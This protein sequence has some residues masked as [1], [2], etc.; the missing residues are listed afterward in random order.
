MKLN[1]TL[2]SYLAL[3]ACLI[4]G[5][6]VVGIAQSVKLSWLNSSLLALLLFILVNVL[7]ARLFGL[8]G[9]L[10][11]FWSYKKLPYLPV[12]IASGGL[13]SVFPVMV[14]LL[15]GK[16][17]LGDITL[18]SPLTLSSIA[19]TLAIVSWEELW[20]RGIFLNYCRRYLSA[21][22]I[23]IVIGALFMLVHV[24]NPAIDLL[25]TG[26]TL[27]FAGAF[28]SIVYFYFRT[29]WLPIGLHFGNNYLALE[30]KLENDSV[31]GNES[32][33]SALIL[34]VLFFVFVRLTIRREGTDAKRL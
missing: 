26:P 10:K 14:A 20:F 7:M 5:L 19:I 11:A 25:K 24:M 1:G 18:S 28:L 4:V 15:S 16:L 13:I 34:A 30:S 6:L 31:F 33:L 29:I 17:S 32:Y 8:N 9:E 21:I 12:G 22:H 3:V 27:F 2:K 23:S